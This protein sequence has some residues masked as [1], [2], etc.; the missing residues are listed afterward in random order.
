MASKPQRKPTSSEALLAYGITSSL[1]ACMYTVSSGKN[2]WR[3]PAVVSLIDRSAL[4][5]KGANQSPKERQL[6]QNQRNLQLL[7]L[8]TGPKLLLVRISLAMVV[9]LPRRC[10]LLP[11]RSIHRRSHAI[12]WTCLAR[13]FPTAHGHSQHNTTRSVR[14][15]RL[16]GHS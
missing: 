14:T 16:R 5:N 2:K 4:H 1:H 6:S 10:A 9:P 11:N 12:C 13:T 8:I 3:V 7:F 15:T